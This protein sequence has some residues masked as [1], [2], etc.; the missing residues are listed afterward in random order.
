M[1]VLGPH[2]AWYWEAWSALH[3]TR[4]GG[5]GGAERVR[6]S[7]VLAY[8]QLT[9]VDSAQDRTDLLATVLRLDSTY[10]KT[11]ESLKG[12]PWQTSDE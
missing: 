10:F 1:P 2:E 9:G 11:R 8:C 12:Q 3:A 7:E 5:L 4:S 6:A